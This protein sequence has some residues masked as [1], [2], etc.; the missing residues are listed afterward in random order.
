MTEGKQYVLG[1][2]E[3]ELE[4]LQRQRVQLARDSNWLFDQLRSLDGAR[5][6]EI[7]CGPH[8]C[9]DQLSRRV[10]PAGSVVGVERNPETVAMTKKMVASEGLAN[11]EVLERDGRSTGLPPSSFDLVMSRLV[12]VNIPHP[13]EDVAEAVALAKPGGWVACHEADWVCHLCDP[14]FGGL[15]SS[16][17]SC[18]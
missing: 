16:F 3:G 13:E 7:G 6:L 14:P 1:Y 10:G 17:G 2:R 12:L 4:R 11:V 18:S 8:G 5:V 9:L 15:D